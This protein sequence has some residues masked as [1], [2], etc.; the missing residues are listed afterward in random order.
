[1]KT[2]MLTVDALRASHLGQYGYY[3][4]TMPVL[5]R[6]AADGTVFEAAYSNAP[7][8]RMSI[9]SFHTSR[10][11]G[12]ELI[13]KTPTIAEVVGETGARTACIGTLTGF[14]D[15]E[16]E[17]VFDEYAD[18]GRDEFYE[19][20]N[21][22]PVLDAAKRV[23]KPVLAVSR[24][25]YR[26]AESVHDRLF[27][28][29]EFKGYTSAEGMTDAVIEWLADA[30]DEFFLWVH[31]MEGHRPYGVHNPDPA[32]LDDPP[33]DE[34]I[35][36]LMAAAGTNPSG[37]TMGEDRLIR[38]LYDSD[39]RYCSHHLDRLFEFM[40]S[41]GLWEETD[42]Y[43]TADHG[44]EFYD[45][46]MYFHRNLPYDELLHVPLFAKLGSREGGERVTETRQLL[47]LAPTICAE[48]GVDTAGLPFRGEHLFEGGDRHV[49]ATGSAAIDD[50]AVVAGRWD[51]WKYI[52]DGDEVRLFD[53]SRDLGEMVSVAA[54]H[55]DVVEAFEAEIPDEL[56]EIDSLGTLD[57]DGDVD[58]EQLAAL[59]Y[60]E[61]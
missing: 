4:D 43:L 61:V 25:L 60:M 35:M 52:R 5:D 50:R 8:T 24:P 47:D 51:G 16:G 12:H 11:R 21:H 19:R 39:L 58:E 40:E 55:G 14:K 44:E 23:A 6:L 26:A 48:H 32:Y 30:P 9:P 36:H 57:P 31:Y 53:L 18:L 20:A 28:T 33:T 29:H 41:D 1:M 17:L 38:D 2:L 45:H 7:Y 27:T 37:V 54:D 34:E 59:G 3:R 13:G 42:V 46:G 22:T 49:V 10:Y 15:S 56:F